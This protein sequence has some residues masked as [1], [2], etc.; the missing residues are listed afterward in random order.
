MVQ[1]FENL[2]I[3]FSPFVK[4][5]YSH[6]VSLKPH[7]MLTLRETRAN[8]LGTSI[9]RVSSP[10]ITNLWTLPSHCLQLRTT[11]NLGHNLWQGYVYV[12]PV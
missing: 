3:W 1:E 2:K 10:K 5:N 9:W 8:C 11:W 4:G 12:P 7:C 6:V